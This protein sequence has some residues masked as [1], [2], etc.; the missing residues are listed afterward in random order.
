MINV[1]GNFLIFL[2]FSL[3]TSL[4]LLQW[5]FMSGKVMNG[6]WKWRATCENRPDNGCK[7]ARN[8]ECY[9]SY[10]P[11]KAHYF[12]S[13]QLGF[14]WPSLLSPHEVN[15]NIYFNAICSNIRRVAENVPNMSNQWISMLILTPTGC[16]DRRTCFRR[17]IQTLFLNVCFR[18]FDAVNQ[19]IKKERKRRRS[20]K[21]SKCACSEWYIDSPFFVHRKHFPYSMILIWVR[22]RADFRWTH[23]H[24]NKEPTRLRYP[25]HPAA[26]TTPK[27]FP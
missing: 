25:A 14:F 10:K 16:A 15:E 18:F 22:V 3:A 1:N 4:T 5:L 27:T 17:E 26:Q 20:G 8:E 21:R 9:L 7:G 19:K 12:L 2:F 6:E 13:K 23:A 24:S 11:L